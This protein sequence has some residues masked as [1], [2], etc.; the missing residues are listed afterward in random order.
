MHTHGLV[1]LD[2]DRSQQVALSPCTS[3]S[4][5][6]MEKSILRNIAVNFAGLIV[7]TAISLVTVPLYI[8]L[9]G[10]ERYGVINLVWALIGY[11]SLLD[12]GTSMATENQIA[13]VRDA[14]DDSVERIFWGA[15]FLN[16]ST[17]IVGAL[18]VY[19]GAYFY[20]SYVV[21]IEPVYRHEILAS[22]P[23]IAIAVPVANV[24]WVFAG[25]ITAVERFGS[26]NTNQTLG[27]MLFQVLPLVAVYFF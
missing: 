10:V 9:L 27:T 21:H 20:V 1:P 19:F 17:G 4:R 24:T 7:P 5:H 18:I 26:F 13:K 23:W 12:L 6:V 11:F 25:A 15:F 14:K 3:V 22:L 16:L 2:L 8:R